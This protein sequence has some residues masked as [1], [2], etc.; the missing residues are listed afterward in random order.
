MQAIEYFR[1]T[2][3]CSL[4]T[5]FMA[6]STRQFSFGPFG[7]LAYTLYIYIHIP[8]EI[9]RS[10]IIFIEAKDSMDG[11]TICGSFARQLFVT[12]SNVRHRLSPN[13]V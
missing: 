13:P 11:V 12:L 9:G 5:A 4:S 8:T 1:V 6:L 2:H 10:W 3:G 7:S